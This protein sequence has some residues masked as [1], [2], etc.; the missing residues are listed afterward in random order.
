MQIVLN[1]EF[2]RLLISMSKLLNHEIYIFLPP[3]TIILS[4]LLIVTIHSEHHMQVELSESWAY[5]LWIN[6]SHCEN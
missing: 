4:S 2:W 6:R 5:F 1:N 3:K